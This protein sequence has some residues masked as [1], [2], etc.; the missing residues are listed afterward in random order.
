MAVI[1]TAILH[2]GNSGR[3]SFLMES[4]PF[5]LFTRQRAMAA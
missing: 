5:D 3:V 4:M 2:R 1:G